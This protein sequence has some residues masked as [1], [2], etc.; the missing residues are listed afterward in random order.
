[1]FISTIVQMA[2]ICQSF[3]PTQG[4]AHINNMIEGTPEQSAL[5]NCK[6][7]YSRSDNSNLGKVGPNYWRGYFKGNDNVLV[8]K[9]GENMI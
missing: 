3:T 7:K 5:T 2:C 4:L 6:A 9:R 8:S 1:M